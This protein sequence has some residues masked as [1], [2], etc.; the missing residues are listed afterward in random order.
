MPEKIQL[1]KE[2][3]LGMWLIA[4]MTAVCGALPCASI[5]YV[6]DNI[7]KGG[8]Y[9]VQVTTGLGE[10]AVLELKPLSECSGG[11]RQVEENYVFFR[12]AQ[13]HIV[14]SNGQ[15]TTDECPVSSRIRFNAH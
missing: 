12:T 13:P 4:L 3:K 14:V 1:G 2:A 7:V 9:I 10:L 5:A 6:S 11:I 8:R 15:I